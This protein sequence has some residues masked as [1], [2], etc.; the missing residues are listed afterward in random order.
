MRATGIVRKIDHL[1]R[2]IIPKEIRKTLQ[3]SDR[4]ALEVFT[5]ENLI[6]LKKYSPGCV[7]CGEMGNTKL[8][9][10]KLLCQSCIDDFIAQSTLSQDNQDN[11]DNQENE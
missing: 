5:D 4:G 11:Q 6:I 7:V 2:I 1:G 3:I 10:K 9:K 8:V